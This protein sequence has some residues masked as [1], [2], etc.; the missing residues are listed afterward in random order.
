MDVIIPIVSTR[1]EALRLTTCCDLV[2]A[3]LQ[4]TPGL[5]PKAHASFFH[6]TYFLEMLTISS[7]AKASIKGRERS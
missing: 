7:Q 5:D 2:G 4:Q 6:A 3:W 1:K